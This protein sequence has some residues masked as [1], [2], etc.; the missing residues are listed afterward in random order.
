MGLVNE[1]TTVG[2]NSSVI[3]YYEKLGYP[4]PRSKD[5]EGRMRIPRGTTI[6]VKTTDLMPSSNQYVDVEC[7]CCGA[8]K[9]DSLFKVQ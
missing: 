5:K 7:D 1:Y 9:K 6:N 4:I 2:L 8:R 3:S